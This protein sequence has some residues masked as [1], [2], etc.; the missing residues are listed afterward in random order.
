[1]TATMMFVKGRC[2]KCREKGFVLTINKLC[3]RCAGKAAI[4]RLRREQKNREEQDK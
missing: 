1:M 3:T 2:K 4:A